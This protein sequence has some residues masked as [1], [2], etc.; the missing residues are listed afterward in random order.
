MPHANAAA[1]DPLAHSQLQE[2]ERDP[3]DDQ[4][5]EVGDQVGTWG[6]ERNVIRCS[7]H[8]TRVRGTA[9]SYRLAH[10]SDS[11]RPKV[12]AVLCSFRNGL[13]PTCDP[14]HTGAPGPPFSQ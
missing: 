14:P 3:D 1:A 12:P 13:P 9:T 5:H 4:Q 2:E 11:P 10:T 8:S 6:G 7:E